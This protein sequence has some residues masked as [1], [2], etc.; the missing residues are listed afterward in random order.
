MTSTMHREPTVFE[1]AEAMHMD[2]ADLLLHMED[3]TV[4]SIDAEEHAPL[5][6]NM[7]DWQQRLELWDI[8]SRLPP[9][10]QQL[11]LLR[12]RVG[13]TQSQAGQR[14]R[15]TQMQVSRRER[16]IRTLL[17]RALSE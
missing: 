8:L 14:L 6:P 10:D 13:M 5:I 15:M 7:D 11:I 17:K 12:H 1:L 4:A 16:I 9:M 2:T 3:I